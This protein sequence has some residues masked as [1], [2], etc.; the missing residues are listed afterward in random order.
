MK[1]L[2]SKKGKKKEFDPY[3]KDIVILV[4]YKKIIDDEK[5]ARKRSIIW[6]KFF[7]FAP[8]LLYQSTDQIRTDSRWCCVLLSA[9]KKLKLKFNEIWMKLFL[10][11]GSGNVLRTNL[12]FP[13]KN[14]Q[15][16]N[17]KEQGI[18]WIDAAKKNMK[19]RQFNNCPTSVFITSLVLSR[20]LH[21]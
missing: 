9:K 13:H 21:R 6:C 4:R 3:S 8:D 2:P 10:W 14:K 5:A 7:L 16:Q 17:Y 11:K 1:E 19:K 12:V 18:D 15:K 20:T